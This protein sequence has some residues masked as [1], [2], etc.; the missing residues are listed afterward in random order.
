MCMYTK[1]FEPKIAEKNILVTKRTSILGFPLFTNSICRNS[2]YL[3]Y[4]KYKESIGCGLLY[5]G[6]DNG[7]RCVE[8]GFHSYINADRKAPN[9]IPRVSLSKTTYFIIPKGAEYYE[10]ADNSTNTDEENITVRVSNQ[11]IYIGK[12]NWFNR[13]IAKIFYGV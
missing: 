10:G 9:S 11:I 4:K 12:R 7:I 1:Q 2:W 6:S 5:C 3:K 13:L 8:E